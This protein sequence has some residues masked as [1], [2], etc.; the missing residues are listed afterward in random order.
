MGGLWKKIKWYVGATLGAGAIAGAYMAVKTHEVKSEVPV[1]I[2]CFTGDTGENNEGQAAVAKAIKDNGCQ[3]LYIAG[4]LIYP[5]SIKSVEDPLLE[6][7][8]L[9]YYHDIPKVIVA[10]GNHDRFGNSDAW[11]EVPKLYPWVVF[12]GYY[13]LYRSGDWCVA[14]FETEVIERGL[15]KK[16]QEQAA[17]FEKLDLTGCKVSVA[18]AHHS[19]RSQGEH[20]DCKKKVC[21][22]YEDHIIGVFDYSIA[23]HD[24]NLSYEGSFK[25]TEVYVSGAGS[26]LRTCKAGLNKTCWERL[27]FLK[28]TGNNRPEFI[29]VE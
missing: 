28:F 1:S 20:S 15:D 24:H 16:T 23:G 10:T 21:R 26:K 8:F 2:R 11:L 17:W 12:P 14:V 18:M 5:T 22:F 29:F 4:D 3:E 6:S 13:Y 9:D 27:G 19:F 7:N 25:G